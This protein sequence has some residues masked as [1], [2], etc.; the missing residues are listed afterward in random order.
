[1]PPWLAK[2]AKNGAMRC[3]QEP[4][5]R[6]GALFAFE[7]LCEKLVRF[8]P[9]LRLLCPSLFVCM[10]VWVRLGGWVGVSLPLSLSLS[11]SLFLPLCVCVCAHVCVCVCVCVYLVTG[12]NT[13]LT[14][15][16]AAL[17][18]NMHGCLFLY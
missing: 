2:V 18:M 8:Q 10:S 9:P 4:S 16:R 17:C 14:R 7:C 12:T 3:V 6:Q 15:E 5:A 13:A 1:M 11:V